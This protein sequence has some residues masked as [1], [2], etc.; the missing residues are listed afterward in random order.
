M[1]WMLK[2][3]SKISWWVKLQRKCVFI[4]VTACIFSMMTSPYENMFRATGPLWGEPQV[5]TVRFPY[6]G[7]RCE[8]LVFS[9]ICAW[10]NGW[11]NNGDAGDLKCH[12]A[13]Y[14]VTVVSLVSAVYTEV[15]D[16]TSHKNGP[17]SQETWTQLQY[18]DEFMTEIRHRL[19]EEK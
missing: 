2:W 18:F 4:I 19:L 12:Y 11:V 5:T 9:L 3:C 17:E 14:D 15:I 7:Q 13:H 1:C 10:T 16:A 6:R 8:A